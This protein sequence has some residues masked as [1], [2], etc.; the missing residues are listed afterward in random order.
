M[1]VYAQDIQNTYNGLGVILPE[2]TDK[3]T[4]DFFRSE[5]NT[6]KLVESH[7]ITVAETRMQETLLETVPMTI[8]QHDIPN[9]HNSTFYGIPIHYIH[10]LVDR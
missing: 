8:T 3:D 9:E 7:S 6:L 2:I 1:Y 10:K 5:A 4:L